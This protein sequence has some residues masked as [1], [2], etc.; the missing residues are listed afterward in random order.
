MKDRQRRQMNRDIAWLIRQSGVSAR[1]FRTQ[2]EGEDSFF[3]SHESAEVE[4]AVVPIE[5]KA[6][7]PKD[8]AEIGADAVASVLPNSGVQE[9]DILDVDGVRYR[10]TEVKPQ[11]CFGAITHFDLHLELEKREVGNE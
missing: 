9:Q 7:S 10:V 3:G 4:V 6:L 11:N 5:I 1:V 8:L 2:R